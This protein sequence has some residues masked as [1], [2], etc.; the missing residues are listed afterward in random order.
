MDLLFSDFL[1]KYVERKKILK[2]R[3]KREEMLVDTSQ[4]ETK[5][6]GI[7]TAVQQIRGTY[8]EEHLMN[9]E[10]VTDDKQ[11]LLNGGQTRFNRGEMALYVDPFTML[12]KRHLQEFRK[13]V[14]LFEQF[15][16]R[17]KFEKVYKIKQVK[18]NHFG[19]F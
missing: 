2:R 14:M 11:A 18:M 13:V 10:I 16:Q 7:P 9:F 5:N 12:T 19:W 15:N 8:D 4:M 6:G 17:K 3:N 1:S